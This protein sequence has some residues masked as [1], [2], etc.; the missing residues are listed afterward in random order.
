VIVAQL[1][2]PDLMGDFHLATATP[3]SSARGR[4]AASTRVGW[5]STPTT[6]FFYTVSAPSPDID[7]QPRP[8]VTGLF[9]RRYDAGS[10]QMTP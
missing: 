8:T 7:G 6:G 3:V 2:P 5:G 1:L 4:G 9:Q 10:D